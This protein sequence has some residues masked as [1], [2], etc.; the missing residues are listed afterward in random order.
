[1]PTWTNET[2]VI[3]MADHGQGRG[4]GA[5]GH[6]SEGERFVPFAMW[7][8]RITKKQVIE[9]PA[10]I[11][12]LAPTI[13]YLLGVEP[14]KGSTGRVSQRCSGQKLK[15]LAVVVPAKD[16]EET[17]GELLDRVSTA[18]H[19]CRLRATETFV[20]DDGSSDRTAEIARDEG[21]DRG[22]SSAQPRARGRGAYRAAGCGRT[23]GPR[24]LPTWTLTW[25]ISRKTFPN[26]VE[27]VLADRTD[28]V[29]GSRF[30]GGVRGMKL[31]RRLGNYAFTDVASAFDETVY[32][33]RPDGD[34]G[35]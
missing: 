15:L 14:P 13:S 5:H 3:L 30:R 31:Y 22:S 17:I 2:T 4:I 29:L 33:R 9:E 16:E 8:S 20:V 10:S 24:W 34:A 6:L 11:L 35:L 26:L 23:L 18:V 7:G 25:S 19:D 21:R 27:P 12:D 28:Y 32:D 1:M